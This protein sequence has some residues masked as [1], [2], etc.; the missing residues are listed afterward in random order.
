LR[1]QIH[2]KKTQNMK[3][4]TTGWIHL[5]EKQIMMMMMMSC[6]TNYSYAINRF[7]IFKAQ[8]VDMTAQNDFHIKN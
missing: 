2:K 6:A 1:K 5:P 4:G 3:E 7:F 8:M